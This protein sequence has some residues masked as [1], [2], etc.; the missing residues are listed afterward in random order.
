[1][2]VLFER[3]E[4]WAGLECIT[5]DDEGD[6]IAGIVLEMDGSFS[7]VH[8]GPTNEGPE[9]D[10][11]FATIDGA[12]AFV[13]EHAGS[14]INNEPIRSVTPAI[15]PATTPGAYLA[16]SS[17]G[18][19]DYLVEW[20]G[21]V[22]ECECPGYSYRGRCRHINALKAQQATTE[23]VTVPCR[24]CRRPTHRTKL[25]DG[26]CSLCVVNNL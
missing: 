9:F 16:P 7:V 18:T 21:F 17:D 24:S 15:R 2:Q 23:P 3:S 22:F 5:D 25:D 8:G 14:M 11:R 26:L 6:W 4:Q 10:H 13:R 20:T 19:R 12:K 1:M